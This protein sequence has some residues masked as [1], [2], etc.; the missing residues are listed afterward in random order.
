VFGL[1]A[2]DD[3][4]L[5]GDVVRAAERAA[6]RAVAQGT[7][8]LAVTVTG[9]ARAVRAELCDAAAAI[10]HE[11]V[12]NVVRHA[13]AR[14]VELRLAFGRSRLRLSVRDDGRGL[15]PAGSEGADHFGI[16]GMRERA[17]GVGASLGVRSVAGGGT[18]VKLDVPYLR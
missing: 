11:A 5:R 3:R 13:A 8:A 4:A 17:T 10:V 14:I 1:R 6:Q 12:T 7:V 15:V 9:R 18:L 16:V 2:G